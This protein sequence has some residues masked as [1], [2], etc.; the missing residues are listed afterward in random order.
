VDL[1]GFHREQY[2]ARAAE[3]A[4]AGEDKSD[5]L[6]ETQIGIKTKPGFT[7]PDVRVRIPVKR[8]KEGGGPLGGRA[9]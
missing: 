4:E 1:I 6:L 8:V 2:L 9:Q 7:V 3:F 5:Y